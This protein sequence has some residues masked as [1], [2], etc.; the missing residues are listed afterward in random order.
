M[1]S[2]VPSLVVYHTTENTYD[3][4]PNGQTNDKVSSVVVPDVDSLVDVG[5]SGDVVQEGDLGAVAPG[6][7]A[8]VAGAVVVAHDEQLRVV[9]RELEEGGD[10]LVA[11]EG[12]A[13]HVEGLQPRVVK[14]VTDHLF[15]QNYIEPIFG[16]VESSQI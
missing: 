5:G 13:R 11:D 1:I 6:V 14:Q 15:R 9:E 16:H 2:D 7:E 8:G 12:V 3:N 10:E 4:T